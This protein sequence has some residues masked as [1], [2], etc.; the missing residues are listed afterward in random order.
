[1]KTLLVAAMLLL[2][3]VGVS[4]APVDRAIVAAMQLSAAPNYSWTCSVTDDARTYDIEG[5]TANGITWQRQPMPQT[6]AKRVGRDGG[7]FLESMFTEPLRYV[8]LTSSGWQRLEEL[9]EHRSDWEEDTEWLHVS[10]PVLRTP[11]MPADEWRTDPFGL[12]PAV[13]VPIVRAQGEDPD[14]RVYS[15]YQFALSLPHQELSV[16]VSSHV[17]MHVE[18][19]IA[20][21]TLSDLGAQLLLV[22]EGHEYIRPVIA[23]G[24]FKLWLR[25]DCVQQY[26]VELAGVVVVSR[27]AVYVRQKSTTRF[28]NVGT[29]RFDVPADAWRRLSGQP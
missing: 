25:E 14:D 16:I 21:G 13:Y 3:T 23:T 8:I 6:V 2:A 28:A 27:K 20:S 5:K 18:G 9:P 7:Y 10:M 1:M 15:N 17:D 12:P 29:T 11:D 26:T 22:H 4:A 24:R 19:D